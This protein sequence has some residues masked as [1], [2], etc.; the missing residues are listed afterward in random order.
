MTS[1]RNDY[2]EDRDRD[3]KSQ[4]MFLKT[5]NSNNLFIRKYIKQ[6]KVNFE[7][8]DYFKTFD[9]IIVGSDQV[10]RPVCAEKIEY[11]FLSF[12]KPNLQI[13]RIAY[14]AS[15]GTNEWEYSKEETSKCAE[16]IK[17]FNSIS[18][19]E[20]SAVGL[21]KDR[22]GVEP[23]FVLDPTMLLNRNHYEELVN[24]EKLKD[25]N[26]EIF[27]YILDST[28]EK[29]NIIKKIS[30]HLGKKTFILGSNNSGVLYWLKAFMDAKFII[31]D[32][33]H[34]SVFSIIFN[35][36][37]IAIG[38]KG[39][40]MARF[41]SLFSNFDL[42]DRLIFD[43]NFAIEIVDKDIDWRKIN[44]RKEYLK[45]NSMDFLSNALNNEN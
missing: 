22:F 27:C 23:D 6:E 12:L 26:G 5:L 33:F 44:A 10:W 18:V 40:G 11:F 34:G 29:S 4:Q 14:A 25:F 37:F 3:K 24:N 15:F 30:K 16:L 38:N 45:T 17:R 41:N 31:T 39:R 19:R 2:Y 42:L 9:A 36:P 21:C 20:Q 43:N 13:K 32:S 35:K 7:D 1:E 28:E 8:I